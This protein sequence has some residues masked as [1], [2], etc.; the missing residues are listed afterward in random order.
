VTGEERIAI[1]KKFNETFS[2]TPFAELRAALLASEDIQD[3]QE[4]LGSDG[5]VGFVFEY[6]DPEIQVD[7]EFPGAGTLTG[8]PGIQGFFEFWRDWLEPW[9]R[10]EAFASNYTVD[11]D[12]VFA[13]QR[14]N[15]EGGLSGAKVELHLC[16]VM[17]IPEG[18][19]VSYAI[20]PDRAKAL[21]ADYTGA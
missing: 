15:A 1:A 10:L 17:T 6:I 12:R 2:A 9:E 18:K 11:G 14:L 8:D 4:N 19:V 5:V 13:D 7:V 3:L 16:Q 21:S 20:Y